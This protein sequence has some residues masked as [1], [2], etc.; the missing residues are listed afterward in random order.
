M[1]ITKPMLGLSLVGLLLAQGCGNQG[2]VTSPLGMA[3]ALQTSPAN[4]RLAPRYANRLV[5]KFRSGT[6]D[7]QMRSFQQRFSLR[8]LSRVSSLGL[9]VMAMPAGK[10]ASAVMSAIQG[11]PDVEYVEPDF[12][13][14]AGP[15]KRRAQKAPTRRVQSARLMNDTL[16]GNQ[17]G[18]SKIGMPSV[19]GM[20]AG[21]PTTV[22]AVIDT[23]VDVRH[24][25]LVGNLVP[26]FSVLPG[27]SGPDDDHGH[28]T[29]VAGVIAAASNNQIGI[30]SVAP[31]CKIMP[32]KVLNKEGKG[33]TSDIV[34]GII[35]ATNHGAKVINMSL[36]GTG[37]SRAL[38]DAINYAKTKDVVLVAAMGN[39][40]ANSQEYP[41]GYPGVIAVGATTEQDSL[42]SFSNYGSWI[43]VTAPGEGIFS[44][45]PT[46]PV[47]VTEMEGKD[48][49]YD[50][51]DGTSMAAPFAAGVAALIRSQ[52]PTM[53][54][55]AVKARLERS[56]DDLGEPG[57]DPEFGHGRINAARAIFGN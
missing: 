42:A 37:G 52:Y 49:D 57:F 15:I 51:M 48:N 50:Y 47:Y 24:P 17:W 25:D 35:W 4:A 28:G 20:S 55:S 26:G 14:S 1:R 56:A 34:A 8:S 5:V 22:V 41:A 44:T 2:V 29:H 36:G 11:H 30:A 18:L 10:S 31:R 43:S 32:V 53:P 46:R 6:S 39:E 38:L 19:W 33:A 13:L 54:A 45:L 16:M 40:G 7:G 21:A 9:G 12:I 23:G 3:P 27:A